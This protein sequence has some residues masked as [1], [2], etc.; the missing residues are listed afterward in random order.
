[1]FS[2][3]WPGVIFEPPPAPTDEQRTELERVRAAGELA[4]YSDDELLTTG[5]NVW[6]RKPA[7]AE[8]R[9][10]LTRSRAVLIRAARRV[11]TDSGTGASNSPFL[12]RAP[13]RRRT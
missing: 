8:R 1:M 7:D 10:S 3:N 4:E 13:T 2:R 6:W 12:V 5:L 9:E 11:D